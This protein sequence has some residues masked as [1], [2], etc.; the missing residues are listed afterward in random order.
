MFIEVVG[1]SG[2]KNAESRLVCMKLGTRVLID[3][4]SAALISDEELDQIDLVL[5]TH[6]HLDHILDLGFI[7]D[8]MI[9]RRTRPLVV[10]GSE[11]CLNIVKT[12]YMNGLLWPDFSKIQV[13]GRPILEYRILSDEVWTD[14]PGGVECMA[15]PVNHPAGARGFL[16]R[17]QG[18]LLVY[19]G[20]TGPTDKIWKLARSNGEAVAVVIEVSFPDSKRNISMTSDHLCPS[21]A[22]DELKKLGADDASIFVFHMKP[23]F[24]GEIEK[25]LNLPG[26]S[27]SLLKPGSRIEFS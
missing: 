26:K 8:S 12:H 18:K 20:D 17:Y 15:V 13:E 10:T 14:L 16:F 3:A 23:W 5:L 19:S 24:A 22:V 4:G 7:L 25:E 1:N 2:S 9:S 11:A 21:L 6:A 27:V